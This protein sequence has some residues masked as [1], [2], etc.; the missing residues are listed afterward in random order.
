MVRGINSKWCDVMIVVCVF[1]CK[2][3]VRSS[4]LGAWGMKC[5][6]CRSY[7]NESASAEEDIIKEP[8]YTV[9]SIVVEQC[10]MVRI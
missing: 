3:N 9:G 7:V 4:A 1:I 8:A 6:K 10:R 2:D 5:G